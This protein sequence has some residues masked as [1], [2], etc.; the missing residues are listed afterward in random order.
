MAA[1]LPVPSASSLLTSVQSEQQFWVI[2][3]HFP[4][5]YAKLCEFL[6]GCVEKVPRSRN[7][8]ATI[9]DSLRALASN[10]VRDS[11]IYWV[12]RGLIFE[13]AQDTINEPRSS[14]GL[15]N[16]VFGSETAS[17]RAK[18]RVDTIIRALPAFFRPRRVVDFGCGDGKILSALRQE[19]GLPRESAIGCDATMIPNVDGADFVFH[20]TDRENGV[21]LPVADG[22]VDLVVALM[23]LHHVKNVEFYLQELSRVLSAGGCLIVREHDC[24][25]VSQSGLSVFLDLVHGLYSLVLS[26]PIEDPSFVKN[27]YAVYRSQ[28]DWRVLLERDCGLVCCSVPKQSVPWGTQ[29]V[30]TDVFRKL[31]LSGGFEATDCPEKR[32][33]KRK[34]PADGSM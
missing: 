31:T 12:L 33:A 26:E 22:S 27:F 4:Q 1:A 13:S 32:S 20:Q 5:L 24:C 17:H 6:V 8:A 29:R 30:F 34:R 7:S 16:A 3:V 9:S 18:S 2:H 14:P 15:V 25:L 19:L 10:G 28:K 23:S 11:T 21:A